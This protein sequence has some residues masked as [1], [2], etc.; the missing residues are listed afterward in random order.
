MIGLLAFK[1]TLPSHAEFSLTNILK[2]FSPGLVLIHSLPRLFVLV[3]VLAHVEDL[4]IG[5]VELYEVH[6]SPPL[7]PGKVPLR[8]VKVPLDGTSSLQCPAE[9]GVIGKL[10]EVALMDTV[11][12]S[13]K[14]VKKYKSQN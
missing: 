8:T 7:R 4:A 14:E 3:T 2:P 13:K 10:A 12:V 1:H 6:T 5:L 11:H 9:L